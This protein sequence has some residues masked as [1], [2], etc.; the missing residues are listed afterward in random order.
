VGRNGATLLH[1]S[2]RLIA[3]RTHHGS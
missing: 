2:K 1:F 3:V